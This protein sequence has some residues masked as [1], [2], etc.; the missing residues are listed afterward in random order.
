MWTPGLNRR[1]F[2]PH[3]PRLTR[4]QG[5]VGPS[6]KLLCNFSVSLASCPG[7]PW[8]PSLV[9]SNQYLRHRGMSSVLSRGTAA[10][11]APPLILIQMK[12]QEMET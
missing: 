12:E 1:I 11:Q 6:L 2:C 8:R 10:N 4:Y 3:N 7:K 9:D 5:T